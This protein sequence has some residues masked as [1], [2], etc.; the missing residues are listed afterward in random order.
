MPIYAERGN[1]CYSSICTRA[2]SAR[3]SRSLLPR[4]NVVSPIARRSA[5]QKERRRALNAVGARLAERLAARNI[6]SDLPLR[7]RIKR[8]VRRMAESGALPTAGNADARVDHMRPAGQHVQEATGLP[9]RAAC[10]GSPRRSRRPYPAATTAS[11]AAYRPAGPL[12]ASGAQARARTRQAKSRRR[13]VGV[14]AISV[15]RDA[16]RSGSA[17]G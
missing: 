10:R 14:G 2:R 1:F 13:F 6:I 11:S 15:E 17:C 8:H 5:R 16:G 9:R 7:E 4:P 3:A 12:R